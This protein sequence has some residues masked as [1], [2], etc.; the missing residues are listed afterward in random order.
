MAYDFPSS[1]TD[2]QIFAPV[3]GPIW[4]YNAARG[5]WKRNAGTA[6]TANKLVNPAMQVSQQNGDN[7][8]SAVTMWIDQW[9]GN[10]SYSQTYQHVASTT[11]RGS[12]YR[13]RITVNNGTGGGFLQFYQKL[14]GNRIA[15]LNYGTAN[16]KYSVLRFGCKGSAGTYTLAMVNAAANRS[17][18]LPFTIPEQVDTEFVFIVPPC[19]TGTW[20]TDN[21]AALK[22][23][24][25]FDAPSG[26]MG[27]TTNTWVT[28][29][30]LGVT[31]QTPGVIAGK[32]FEVFDV[33]WYLDANN[34]GVAPEFQVPHIE[35]D[36]QDCLRYW[37][38][39]Y[40]YDGVVNSG[41]DGY[42]WLSHYV[43]M[44]TSPTRTLVGTVRVYDATVAP[45]IT[46]I[47]SYN[48][49]EGSGSLLITA[50]AGGM[51]VGRPYMTLVDGQTANYIAV[52]AR[53]GL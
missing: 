44:C 42:A 43:P 28:G 49:H 33:G 27:T 30:F 45:N 9:V 19:T 24:F 26:Q 2:G 52:D 29:S 15:D 5:A 10:G 47:T 8:V 18:L 6:S 48:T 4:A 41:T 53:L 32:S 25:T 7:A 51:T 16:A 14:E 39:S 21:T 3:S 37:Y 36:L 38:P 23:Y 50:S 12:K 17:L 34:T 40:R 22:F 11:P 46:S 35:D 20:V 1:P 13:F 31:G